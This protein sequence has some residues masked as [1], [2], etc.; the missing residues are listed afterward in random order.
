MVLLS[1]AHKILTWV[2]IIASGI[3]FGV[4][5][6]VIIADYNQEGRRAG[7]SVVPGVL[8]MLY[9]V[10]VSILLIAIVV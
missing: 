7:S 10:L 8:M 2:C 9:F 4:T 6:C 1:A 3:L 5:M